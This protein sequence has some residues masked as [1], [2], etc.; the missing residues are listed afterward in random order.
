LEPD[1][2]E[3]SRMSGPQEA[4]PTGEVRVQAARI[5]ASDVMRRAE[6][7]RDLLQYFVEERIAR[8]D[9]PASQKQ[10][11]TIVLGAAADF[12][13]TSN[14]H[15]R[16]YVRRLRKLLEKYYAGPGASDPLMLGV[17]AG[18]Y[19]LSVERRAAAGRSK[20]PTGNSG[21]RSARATSIV[22][23]TEFKAKRLEGELR[24]LANE[25][26]RHLV[27]HLLGEDGIVAIGPIPWTARTAR[28]ACKSPGVLKTAA[29][30]LLEGELKSGKPGGNG[31]RTIE[32]TIRLH[33]IET[34]DHLWSQD[35]TEHCPSR[36][37]EALPEMIAARLVAI[38]PKSMG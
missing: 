15:V 6:K 17:T 36:N 11:A 26:P 24:F 2:P 13:P 23:L 29:D 22:L 1:V 14:A 5:L 34:G 9:R 3:V 32:I 4:F 35:C 33:D 10:I 37:L 25:V 20:A 28:D 21:R 18:T 7:L 12:N 38:M 30:F 16:I 8:G 31:Q 27:L 19:R